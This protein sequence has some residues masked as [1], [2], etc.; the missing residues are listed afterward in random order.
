MTR[1]HNVVWETNRC[2]KS[3]KVIL[4]VT[5]GSEYLLQITFVDFVLLRLLLLLLH[6]HHHLLLLLLL[7][8]KQL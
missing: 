5:V 7:L 2:P 4:P 1:E 8:P 6:H 3:E